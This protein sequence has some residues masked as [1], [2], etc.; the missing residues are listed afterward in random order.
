[1]QPSATMVIEEVLIYQLEPSE[2]DDH[3]AKR[4]G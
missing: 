4:D 2:I 3:I 1:M